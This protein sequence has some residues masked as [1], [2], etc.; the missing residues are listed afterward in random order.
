MTGVHEKKNQEKSKN[1]RRKSW[2]F[3][4]KPVTLFYQNKSN[5]KQ[6]KQ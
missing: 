1:F 4:E 5:V 6:I 2:K 3:H